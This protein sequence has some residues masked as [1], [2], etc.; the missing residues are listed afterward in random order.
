MKTLRKL[1]AFFLNY[2]WNIISFVVACAIIVLVFTAG[3]DKINFK[4]IISIIKIS[5]TVLISMLGFSVSIYV[6]LNNTLQNRR[7]SNELEREVIEDFQNS[8]KKSLCASILFSC[9]AITAE[10]II[11]LFKDFLVTLL[12]NSEYLRKP[13]YLIIIVIV[14]GITALNIYKLGYFTYQV[15]NYEEGL[16]KL[17]KRKVRLYSE[18]SSY[19][20]MYKGEFLNLVNNLEVLVE[21]LV[22]NHL[23]AKVS[24]EYDTNLKRAICDGITDGGDIAT[25]EQLAN[26]YKEII[27]YRNLLIQD[28]TLLDSDKVIMGDKVKSVIERLFQNYLKNELLTGISISNLTV[29]QANLEKASFSNSSLQNI[30]FN[31]KTNLV[32]TDFRN[33]TLNNIDFPEANC[34]SINFSE[35]KL[36]DVK[37]NPKMILQRAIFTNADL[38][39]MGD[40]GSEDKEG[41]PIRFQH[42][43]FSCANITHQDIYNVCFDFSDFSNA[44]L[45][46]SIIGS[47]AQK[48]NNVTFKYA[49]MEKVDLLRCIIERCDFQNANL[50]CAIFTYANIADVN[51]SESRM[52][53][54]NLVQSGIMKCRFEKAYCTDFSLKGAIIKDSQFTYAIMSS[55]DLSGAVLNNIDFSDSVCRD[56]LWI[57]TQISNSHFERCVLANARIV[58]GSE[59]KICVNNCDF[60]YVDLSNSAIANIEFCNCDFKGADLSNARLINVCFHD[61]RNLD[62]VVTEHLWVGEIS[63][64]GLNATKLKKEK[65][66]RYEKIL[67]ED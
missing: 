61:C 48:M 44:R 15:I 9:I 3:I 13:I 12:E 21:R 22:Q 32:N 54:A 47:S 10:V 11:V 38:S 37:F 17:A 16:K 34:D 55:A 26:D 59:Q 31:R 8:K 56:T 64:V 6:F 40:I 63:Y 33:S 42:A 50:N 58:G 39:G 18:Q 4:N 49:D 20:V 19:G 35:C 28:E 25:R 51:F 60:S 14:V 53:N 66:W 43:N 62:D 67:N 65:S 45:I 29:E 27:D 24:T 57:R 41:N 2:I 30:V 52:N 36:I 5:V 1:K 46:D 7:G 23:Y